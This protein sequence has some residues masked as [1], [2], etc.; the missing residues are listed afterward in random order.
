[1][2]TQM[3]EL[4]SLIESDPWDDTHWANKGFDRDDDF[5]DDEDEQ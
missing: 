3:K 4:F 2:L 1:M 5:K